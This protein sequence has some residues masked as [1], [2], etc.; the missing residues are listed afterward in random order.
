MD[1]GLHVLCEKLMARTSRQCKEMIKH[2]KDKGLLLSIGHQR[3]YS[4]LYAQALEVIENGI[5]GD[6]KH[7]RA[8]WHRNNSWPY[9][10]SASTRTK[11]AEEYGIPLLRRS[12]WKEVPN[13]DAEEAH[14]GRAAVAGVRRPGRSTASRTWRSWSAGGASTRPAAG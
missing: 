3:H 13:E 5:L 10:A 7:I 8:L 1:A 11:F 12:W 6:I 14:P 9:N 4:T 2:A